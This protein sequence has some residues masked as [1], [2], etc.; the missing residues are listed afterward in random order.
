MSL[1]TPTNLAHSIKSEL[2]TACLR[3]TGSLRLEVT[4][5]SMLPTI[6]P[7]DTLIISTA[8]HRDIVSGDIGLFQREGNIFVHR[9][10]DK[11]DSP[12]EILSRGDAMPQA[13]PPFSSG[14]L[15]GKVQFIVRHGKQIEASRKLGMVQRLVAKLMQRSEIACRIAVRAHV[16][17]QV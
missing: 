12:G 3:L 2:A 14:E 9:V 5:W 8:D 7:G 1:S 13:D 11:N 15:A 16:F 4:G 10:I 6:W 17:Y